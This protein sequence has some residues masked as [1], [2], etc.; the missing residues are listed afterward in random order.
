MSPSPKQTFINE[1][2][3]TLA[4]ATL[5]QSLSDESFLVVLDD[6]SSEI[7]KCRATLKPPLHVTDSD[8]FDDSD[9]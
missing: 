8:N 1:A 5:A 3:R 7:T 9:L 4:L 6:L 2:L